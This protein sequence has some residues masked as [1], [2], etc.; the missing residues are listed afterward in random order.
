MR[1]REKRGTYWVCPICG[2]HLDCGE[3]CDCQD[4]E[5]MEEKKKPRAAGPRRT[6]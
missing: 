6:R 4:E 2:A 1:A 5:N 3:R